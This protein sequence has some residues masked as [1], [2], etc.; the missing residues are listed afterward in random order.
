[1]GE[2]RNLLCTAIKS[3]WKDDTHKLTVKDLR[4]IIQG[5][6]ASARTRSKESTAASAA[7]AAA[8]EF[9]RV[10]A[11]LDWGISESKAN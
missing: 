3:S 9:E 6:E 10:V 2:I 11:K 7:R 8:F 4:A 1:M 5:L